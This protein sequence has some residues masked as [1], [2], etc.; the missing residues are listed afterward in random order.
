MGVG[1][2]SP[3]SGGAWGWGP[4]RDK[5]LD[6]FQHRAISLAAAFAHG[7]E[8]VAAAGR[9]EVVEQGGGHAHPA[10][11][12]GVAD[13]YSTSSGVELLRVRVELTGPSEDDGGEGFVALD[14]IE[15]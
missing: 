6:P 4:R 11:S 15:V 14:G 3:R 7:L 8:A 13:G 10:G 5:S 2:G 1:L 12:E 9:F